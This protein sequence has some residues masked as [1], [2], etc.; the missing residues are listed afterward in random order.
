MRNV[1]LMVVYVVAPFVAAGA[2]AFAG[3]AEYSQWQEEEARQALEASHEI[4]VE[5]A[6]AGRESQTSS[7]VLYGP[8]VPTLVDLSTRADV[9]V[10]G[11]RGIGAVGRALLGSTSDSLVR[12]AHCPVAVIHEED[13]LTTRQPHAPVVV[14]IDG[15]PSSALATE[16]AFDEA[17][18][19]GVELVAVHAWSDMGP[20]EFG[21]FGR[22]PIEW[23]NLKV[24]E[25]E[26]L[27]ERLSGWRERYPDV[28]VHKMVV[29][30]RPVPRLLEQ[31]ET[32]QLLVVG[33]R[34][35]GGFT[36]M[37]LGSVSRAVVNSAEIPVIVART[38]K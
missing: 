38:P 35:R 3:P 17:S 14:G 32:A 24:E 33:S 29:S 34:G 4:A 1:P 25:Q 13:A 36:G 5:A 18:R 9:V 6:S 23:A 31:A 28:V 26:V 30:D 8:I 20:L 7:E 16:I 15:S 37:L 11:C 10:V 19:R 27:S 22:A 12:H 21:S 2:P